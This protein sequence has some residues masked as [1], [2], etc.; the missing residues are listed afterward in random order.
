MDLSLSLS[1]T[2]MLLKDESFLRQNDWQLGA[3]GRVVYDQGVTTARRIS[4]D[5]QI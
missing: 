4:G 2:L 1:L 5:S 3:R